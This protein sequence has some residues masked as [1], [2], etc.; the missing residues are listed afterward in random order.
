MQV[1]GPLSPSRH[2]RLRRSSKTE[3]QAYIV[4]NPGY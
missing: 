3:E 2:R 4:D 1:E